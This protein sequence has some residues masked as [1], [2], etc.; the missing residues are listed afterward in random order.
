[1]KKW[2]FFEVQASQ[3]DNSQSVGWSECLDSTF[4]WFQAIV[5][6]IYYSIFGAFKW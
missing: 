2:Q 4:T 3:V 6:Q 5:S 1:M